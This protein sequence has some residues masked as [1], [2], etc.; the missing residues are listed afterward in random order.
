MNDLIKRTIEVLKSKKNWDQVCDVVDETIHIK[1][2]HEGLLHKDLGVNQGKKLTLSQEK[3]ALHSKD[4]AVR[5]RANFA[6]NARKFHHEE[7][8]S[9]DEISDKKLKKYRKSAEKEVF[10]DK[11]LSKLKNRING[12]IKAGAR[13][14]GTTPKDLQRIK[15]L[16][17]ETF[18]DKLKEKYPEKYGK[19]GT[20]L[21]K[22]KAEAKKKVADETKRR[23]EKATQTKSL[24]KT[25]NVSPGR[26]KKIK[27]EFLLKL[28]KYLDKN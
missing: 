16:K 5:K 23:R 12:I 17:E 8:E 10:D 3:K 21:A 22:A 11:N 25:F 9:L 1:K 18:H 2:S 24:R 13:L 27:E 20:I 14:R 7:V 4:P 6:I 28:E 19:P 15:K 26:R